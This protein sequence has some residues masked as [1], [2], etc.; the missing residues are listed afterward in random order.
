MHVYIKLIVRYTDVSKMY[1]F[2]KFIQSETFKIIFKYNI[3]NKRKVL[4]GFIK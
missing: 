1:I 4:S 3:S 2:K